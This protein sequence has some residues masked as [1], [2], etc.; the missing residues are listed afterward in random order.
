M[1]LEELP[2]EELEAG[3][4]VVTRLFDYS[5]LSETESF[6]TPYSGKKPLCSSKRSDCVPE[7]ELE[8]EQSLKHTVIAMHTDLETQNLQGTRLCDSSLTPETKSFNVPHSEKMLLTS[9]KSSEFATK[10]E[11]E[12][13]HRTKCITVQM[14]EEEQKVSEESF[15]THH[16]VTNLCE[17]SLTPET[18][19][20]N[21]PHSEEKPQCSSKCSDSATKEVIMELEEQPL[22][23]LEAGVTVVTRLFDYSLLSETESF[24]TPYSGKKPLCSSKRSDCVPEEELEEEQS[25]KH[26]A[27]AMHTD[28]ETQN[29][30]GTRLCDSSL[31]PETKSFNV[32]HS[33]EKP[34]CSSICSDSATKE[35]I[36]Q[37]EELPLEELEAGVMVVTRLFDYSL[38]SET[39]SFSTPYSGKKPLCSS[40][41]SDCVPEEELEEEQSRKH[42]AIAMH[43]DLETQN[44]QGT[45]LCDSS[46]TPETKSFNVPHSEKML[47]SS[48]KS[49]ESATKEEPEEEHRTKCITVQMEEEEQKVSE[50]SFIT[51]HQVTNL[52]EYSLT[53]ETKSF[54]VPHS[55]EKPQC[56]SKC[57]DSATKEVIMEL[58]ELPLEELEAGVTVV[59]RLFDYSLLSET[60]SFSTP[61]SGKKPLCSSK[62]SDCVPEEELEEEQ[63][64]KHTVIAMH[65]DLETQNLQGTR[66]C[67]SSLTP[68]TKSFNVPHSEEKPQCSSKCSDSAT[69]E[70][71][72]QL[73]E[74]PLEELEAGVMVVT[75]LFDYSLLSET[76]SFSTPY[77]GK[78]P[79]CSSKR[80]DCVPEEELEEEQNLKHTAIAM[81]TDLETQNLQGTRLCDSSLTPETKSF[82]VPHSEKMLLT[83]GKS[84]E[85]ATKEEP[86]EEHRTK[87]I[88]VQMEVEEQKVSEESFITHHQVT[89]LC[90]YSL[91]PETKSFNVPHSEEKPQCSSK[92]SDSATKEVIMELE[93]QPLEELEA[94]VT[95]VTRLFDYSLLSETESFSTPY[96]GKKPLCSSKRSDCVPEEELEEEQSR[97]HT[98]IAMHTDLE[99]QNFHGTRLCDS[100]LRPET[101]SFNVPHSEEK[102]QCSSI[103]SDSATKEIIMQ[104]EELPLEE[105]EAG[106]MVVTRLFDY[107]LLSETESFS[108]PYS[109][110]KPLCSSKRS[111]CV[112]EEELEEEQSRKHTAIAMHTDLETQNLQGTRLCDS[113]L[114]PETKSFNVPHSEKMLLSSGKSSESATKEE[115]EEEHRTKCITVQMEEEEQKVSEES[116]ITHH[117]VTNLCEYSLTPETKSFNVPHSEEKPQCSSKC[118]DSA[119][120]EVIME[121]EELPLEE[122]EAGVTVV[123]RLFDYSLLSETES[124]STP[125]SGKKP[126]CSSK[127]SDCVPEEELEEEQSLKHTVIAMHTDLETQNLQGTRLCDSSLTPET[128]SFNVPHSEEKPQ[129][130]SKCSDSATK[131]IIMQLEELP[132][133][134]LE[135]GVMVVTR[136]FDYSLL[137]ETESFSTPYSGKKPLCSSKRSDCVPEEE[138]EEEQNLKHTAIAMHTD[139]ET[140][141][142][143]GTRLCDSS[144]TPETK[145]FNVPHSE[146]MLLTS[147]KS[148]EFATKEEPE[149]EH[150]TKCITVQMEV[151]E[152]KVSEESFITHHQV[153]NLCEYSLTPETKSF[154]VPHSEEKPQCSSKCS[155][156]ATKEV[157]MELEEQPLEE[158]EAGVTVVTRLFDYSL[159]SETES[160]STPYSGKKPLCSSKRSDCVPEEELEEEQSRKH[161]AIAMHT[162]LETQ[163]F[164]G[165]RLCDSSLR[166]ETKSFNVPH[167]EEK[168]QCSSICSDSATKEIIMQLEELPLEELEAGVMVVT[169]LFDYSLLSETESFSTPYS[170]KKPLCSSKRSDCV[171]EEELEEEQSRKHTAIAMHTD[172]ETQNLQ[173]TRLCDSS[174]TPETKSF[175]VPH[176]EKMLLS[177][178]KSSESATKEEPEEEHRT[179]CITV[180]ME[181]EEQK[182]SEESFITHHQVTNLCEYSLTPETKSFNVPHSEEKPQCSSKCSD[183]ATKEVIMELEELPL[184]ELEA[185]VTVVTRLFDYSLLSETESFSTPYSGKKPLCS[186][187]RSDCVP[188]EE[189]EEEQSLK[190]TVIAMHTDLE[191]QNLQGTRLCD[192]SLTP[193]TKSFNVPHSE[194]KPQCSSK[195]SDSATKEIIMQLEELPLEELEAGVMVVTRLFDYSLLSET[196]SFSTPYS[197]K[198]PLCSSK[199]SDCVPEEELEE[200]QNLKHTAIAMHTDLETQNLQGTRLCDSSLTPET[201]SFNVPHSEKMLLTSGKSSEFATKEEPEEEHRTKCITVQMEVEEQKV[202]EES[203]ITHHQVTNLCEYSLTPETKSF[204]VPHSEEKPQ[205]SSKCSDSATKEVIMELEEQPLEELEAGVTVVTRLF[206]YSLLSETESFSTP[207]SGKKPLCSSKRSDCVPEEELEEE[208]SRKHTAI[209]MHTD[210]E[211]QNFHG[212]RLCDSSLRPET[213]SFNVPHSEEKPQCSSICS[214]SATKE[215]IM[216]LE[217]LPLE[218]LEAGVMVV[219]RLFDYSLLSETE[220]FSTPYSGKKP[221]C[222]SKRSDCVPEEELEEEQSR[223]HTAIAMHTDLETQNLQGTRLCDSSL[224]PETKSF[225]VPHSEK[226]L[227]SSG[228]SSE[229]ATKEEPE[230]EHRTKCITVQMEEEEQKVS[231]ESFITHHQVTNLCEYSLTPETKSFNVPHSEEKPQCSSKCSDSAT[232]EVIME[233]LHGT[234]L[235]DSSLTPETKSFNVPHSEKRLLNS[236]KSFDS[237]CKADLEDEHRTK[238]TAMQMELEEHLLEENKGLCDYSLTPEA[239]KEEEQGDENRWTFCNIMPVCDYSL[240][241]GSF[242]SVLL[243][244]SKTTSK[245]RNG[246]KDNIR[247]IFAFSKNN[248]F[249][250][251]SEDFDKRAFQRMFGETKPDKTTSHFGDMEYTCTS[252]DTSVLRVGVDKVDFCPATESLSIIPLIRQNLKVT[253]TPNSL[254]HVRLPPIMASPIRVPFLT[255][256]DKSQRSIGDSNLPC[257]LIDCYQKGDPHPMS[258]ASAETEGM[259]VGNPLERYNHDQIRTSGS[260]NALQMK[261]QESEL[262]LLHYTTRSRTHA[263]QEDSYVERSS[264]QSEMDHMLHSSTHFSSGWEDEQSILFENDSFEPTDKQENVDDDSDASKM[265]NSNPQEISEYP[266]ALE[267][268]EPNQSEFQSS[269]HSQAYRHVISS[270]LMTM[271]SVTHTPGTECKRLLRK[272]KEL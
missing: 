215:I 121:L 178:G 216:Q 35:I 219:T 205:C 130:S 228:K 109:G 255:N 190:H 194:E 245:F 253:S 148:S 126:L 242:S 50:E 65:T 104:L 150:R 197:G 30:H 64:L 23:E 169:R 12:E 133:E 5:L 220:S 248:T 160:F 163:N 185:G 186:S 101:K 269:G 222:S 113:S 225:N 256:N 136:L 39:E 41:R 258:V 61:Y 212:T 195:C 85:F 32:P 18:K 83:S 106:V 27:I 268:A 173:G 87:C 125:Y 234:R 172:L 110:K 100:S 236:N 167:S 143:Q 58:E 142:L 193:E 46:L 151:E 22:E 155:D 4:M 147:G 241:P 25:R 49:S 71:I 52:C 69:K 152:Q 224:T 145:S 240:T 157:I 159:L 227:L 168:P 20:F 45:R 111:D 149:E 37:L 57:S 62:R 88:T 1:Q 233:N 263:S 75:R 9:G 86:E 105:L 70:I 198:K 208:Q 93:E 38:L 11:P 80:S 103:C 56:S 131:E 16:Q 239:L 207:Y 6:S 3:V 196:E 209:A 174:L 141:N 51:H 175:N 44:L 191:T 68:E 199:R 91:T 235:C 138:L 118:S 202:S 54:N 182:V 271:S 254:R 170:G 99:T 55:E 249:L 89:N 120:K 127:R 2:L 67:D 183:S 48:G 139:L 10:E 257:F 14:E 161:T 76:E 238:D 122:L 17:Y 244:H 165:T 43:T 231:E 218:E 84:S 98:A 79:L 200:E 26:T 36:M 246:N 119:T 59:T 40:K 223:K 237:A 251:V 156:S 266:G 116:F 270:S 164:H 21:V 112:P 188:E 137:S 252:P 259:A 102:P 78:K 117:Q 171:P 221:L 162:D 135:A 33:E 97:K 132:L 229:S 203:F 53:P 206:D 177:S 74:L 262:F 201:K 181:E 115:P 232:K 8:E 114:T 34:Q 214:D 13:E 24:S 15:I 247:P 272:L 217:E 140:Q 66:L 94:G 107:S 179:K 184:E 230:E 211:T 77:S 261:L 128:K 28:L 73:E 204:N 60:E 31:R 124:F 192:S 92:C 29:F 82:N 7:E 243:A 95:V 81:H 176:S 166:P 158:L 260:G 154:N 213:K 265:T 180:Q 123:T 19:S 267:T 47:L 210:L 108:T 144:L 146:K 250:A 63:S 187:K 153:T 264:Q 90:E 129:C 42:T 96:S 189:L 72:M 134:E 226:M